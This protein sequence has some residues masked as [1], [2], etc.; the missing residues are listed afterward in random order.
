LLPYSSTF[1]HLIYS[2]SRVGV[3]S[4]GLRWNEFPWRT[5]KEVS[6]FVPRLRMSW[7]GLGDDGGDGGDGVWMK[8]CVAF[9][10]S[11]ETIHDN[12]SVPAPLWL[13]SNG[14]TRQPSVFRCK[15][16]FSFREG[17]WILCHHLGAVL[18]SFC[19]NRQCLLQLRLASR[20]TCL[21][22]LREWLLFPHGKPPR[23]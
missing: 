8:P 2:S 3:E 9:F 21:T 20:R 15:L 1:T 5:S 4:Q 22:R 18:F 13:S 7:L 23:C 10:Q 12:G 19:R 6:L 11:F 17:I 14:K 16:A